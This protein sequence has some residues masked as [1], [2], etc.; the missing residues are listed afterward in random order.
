MA[1]W[2]NNHSAVGSFETALLPKPLIHPIC[3]SHTVVYLGKR[4]SPQF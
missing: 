2:E 4:F 1:V 3:R